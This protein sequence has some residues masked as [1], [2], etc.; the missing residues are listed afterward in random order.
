MHTRSRPPG[1]SLVELLA[2]LVVVGVLAASA[3]PSLA[4]YAEGIR[5]R[6]ALDRVTADLYLARVLAVRGG[7]PVEI[8]FLPRG[9]ECVTGYSL[10]RSR[11]EVEL[12]RV[13]LREEAPG[14]CL[15]VRGGAAIRI[16]ARGL[17]AGAARTL[18][19]RLGAR[20]DSLRVSMVGRVH[21]FY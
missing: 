12:S 16:D 1:F 20:S 18:V 15:G 6:G 11:D 19:G 13:R 2:V 14:F 5:R 9:A 10:V 3:A 7:E 4:A 17:P 8:R 21:R